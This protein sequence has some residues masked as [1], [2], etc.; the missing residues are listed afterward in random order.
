MPQNLTIKF[1]QGDIAPRYTDKVKQ[2]EVH[3]AIVTEKGMVGGKPL[4]DFQIKDTDG[5]EYFFMITG[6]LCQMLG[7]A[8]DGVNLRN[9]GTENP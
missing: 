3:T 4:V 6:S 2:L 1:E 5:N 7:K 8:I 9:H